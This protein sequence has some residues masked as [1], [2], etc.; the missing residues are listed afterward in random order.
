LFKEPLDLRVLAVY[1]SWDRF[2]CAVHPRTGLKTLADIADKRYPLKVSVRLDP[3]HAT[4]LLLDDATA[5]C[6]F[7]LLDVESWGGKVLYHNRPADSDRMARI[8]SG[9]L[10]AVFDEGVH[11]W[12]HEAL[13]AGYQPIDMGDAA[14]RQLSSIGWGV[15][16][17]PQARFAGLERDYQVLDFS[18]WALYCRT[19][20]PDDDAYRVC[21]ALGARSELVP[22]E[23][24]TYED[25]THPGRITDSTPRDVP[26]HPG[27][28]RW[29]QEH[30]APAES[31]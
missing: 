20:L 2:V 23:E 31:L 24:G 16:T 30:G 19:S 29:Y 7:K 6:G 18:G 26:L 12:V 21:D 4:R 1:P 5:A 25:V 10:D 3:T 15:V 9:E 28:K 14:L 8:A 22:W 17:L 11:S 13:D 27:A